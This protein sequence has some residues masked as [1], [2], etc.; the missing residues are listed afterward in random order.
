M[1]DLQKGP[2]VVG[3][4]QTL[5]VLEN[6]TAKVLYVAKN[7]QKQVTLRVIEIAESKNIPIVYIETMEELAQAC[8]VEV[9][10]ATAALIM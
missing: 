5:R 7:A 10:T 3:T 9:K 1:H 4:K 8:D 6:G 2:K